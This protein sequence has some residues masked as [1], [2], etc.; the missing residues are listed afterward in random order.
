[1]QTTQVILVVFFSSAA[2]QIIFEKS[3]RPSTV[4]TG[5]TLLGEI[6]DLN[7]ELLLEEDS[8]PE[9]FAKE[10]VKVQ[11]KHVRN[12][13]MLATLDL[14][15]VSAFLPDILAFAAAF[16]VFKICATLASGYLEPE[17]SETTK[18]V[19]EEVDSFGCTALHLAAHQGCLHEVEQ[20]L[21]NGQDPN[22]RES[23]GETPLH[24]A[25]RSGWDDICSVLLDAGADAEAV[26]KDMKTPLLLA[27]WAGH[28]STFQMLLGSACTEESESDDFGCTPLHLAAHHGSLSEMTECLRDGDDPNACEAWGE[29]PL[30][31]AARSG[32]S[33]ACAMLLAAGANPMLKNKDG[34]TAAVLAAVA[35][36]AATCRFLFNGSPA[37]SVELDDFGCSALHLAAHGADIVEVEKL[38]RLR[39]DPSAR[40]PWHETP[41]HMAARAGCADICALLLAVGSE[42]AVENKDGNTALALAEYA[43]HDFVCKLLKSRAA[44]EQLMLQQD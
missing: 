28:S 12:V 4:H 8:A 37:E 16:V 19:D 40:E 38:L 24:M 6:P 22:E 33:D 5:S 29:T 2:A 20:H 43:G 15:I 34:K 31:L 1:M 36:H 25:A 21:S 13:Q 27:A 7:A 39:A 42:F 10:G 26:N 23:F 11:A 18:K 14:G 9:P 32:C 41:L 17:A 30:H 35:G 44:E 3:F